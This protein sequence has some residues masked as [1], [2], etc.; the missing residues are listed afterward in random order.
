MQLR[1]IHFQPRALAVAC[2]A[3]VVAAA[4]AVVVL[5]WQSGQAVEQARLA[6]LAAAGDDDV[7]TLLATWGADD[8]DLSFTLARLGDDRPAVNSA[9]GQVL[10]QRLTAWQSLRSETSSPLV[11]SLARTLADHAQRRT[12]AGRRAASVVAQRILLW[13]LDEQKVD[14]L[15]VW[16]DCDAVLRAAALGNSRDFMLAQ[17]TEPSPGDGAMMIG[18]RAPHTPAAGD[19]DV[20]APLPGGGLPWEA[21]EFPAAPTT[22]N[23]TVNPPV[24][25]DVEE[26]FTAPGEIY[27]PLATPL[28]LLDGKEHLDDK[29][30]EQR[31]A[32]GSQLRRTDAEQH[33]PTSGADDSRLLRDLDEISLMKRLHVPRAAAAAEAELR[34]RGHNDNT[35]A[36]A[37]KLTDADPRVRQKLADLLPQLAGV[38]PQP[39]LV[40]LAHDPHPEVRRTAITVL[41][42]S[43]QASVTHWLEHI[44]DEETDPRVSATIDD[45]L[46]KRR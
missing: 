2:L 31:D 33:R 32:A 4:V 5:R 9:A 43:D 35:L 34:R 14:P 20:A 22:E 42:S 7:R 16:A 18:R 29:T 27:A 41:A 28:D 12:P 44:R 46:R 21:V 25:S 26:P 13:P 24:E 11:A 3:A 39:W 10:C 45:L 1:A 36:L 17:A 19:L 37:R 6:T 15:A 8:D 23:T 40:H 38:D 30:A